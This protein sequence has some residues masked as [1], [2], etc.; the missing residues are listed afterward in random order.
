MGIR[1]NCPVVRIRARTGNYE[2]SVSVNEVFRLISTRKC[3]PRRPSN[4]GLAAPRC[5]KPFRRWRDDGLLSR[6]RFKQREEKKG[7]IGYIYIREGALLERVNKRRQLETRSYDVRGNGLAELRLKP[8]SGSV[9]PCAPRAQ[10]T[11]PAG[12]AAVPR[13][14][15]TI[16]EPFALHLHPS[17]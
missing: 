11:P 8:C 13:F 7:K 14:R 4:T 9:A 16:R 6:R 17:V 5:A 2:L 12:A 15:R 1:S 3:E 10:R